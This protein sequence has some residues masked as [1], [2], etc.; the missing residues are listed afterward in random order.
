MTK[1]EYNLTFVICMITG[2]AE[3]VGAITTIILSILQACGVINAHWALITLPTYFIPALF[4]IFGIGMFFLVFVSMFFIMFKALK[5]GKEIV[6]LEVIV[7]NDK[8]KG[9]D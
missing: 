7:N 2:R 8:N 1:K 6:G 4:A 5:A 3:I 9:Q